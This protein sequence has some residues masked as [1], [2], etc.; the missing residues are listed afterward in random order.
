M[1]N[2][3]QQQLKM[4]KEEKYVYIYLGNFNVLN[5]PIIEK[6]EEEKEK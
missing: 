3:N 1:I 4:A 5:W 2:R 6:E